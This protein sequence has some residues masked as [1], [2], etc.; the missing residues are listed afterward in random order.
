MRET[1]V[2]S[3]LFAKRLRRGMTDAERILWSRLR[4][5]SVHG[6]KF[7]RQHPI[8]PYIADFACVKHRLI[9][10]VDGDTHSTDDE[11][12]HDRRRDAYL[13]KLGWNVVRVFNIDVYKNLDGVL[14]LIFGSIPPPP[15]MR[16]APPP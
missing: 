4:L 9:V 3:R 11:I 2:K 10:E 7:R 15:R 8:G 1:E 12:A 16:A 5:K 13:R 6:W 14:D